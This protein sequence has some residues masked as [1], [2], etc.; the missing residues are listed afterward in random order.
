MLRHSVIRVLFAISSLSL[1][2]TPALAA[3]ENIS[4]KW[5]PLV[6]LPF[7]PSSGAT[8]PNG[9]VLLWSADG[10]FSF[11]TG[12]QV[13]TTLFDPATNASTPRRFQGGHNM[14]CTGTTNLADGRIL[15]N[16]GSQD[17]A[18]TIY[19]P[20]SNLLTRVQN[21]NQPRG[22]NSNT[23]LP[24]GS[25]LTLGGSWSGG[26]AD[27][28]GEVWTQA[29]GWRALSGVTTAPMT[30]SYVPGFPRD[31]HM[32]IAPAGNGRVFYAGPAPEM[33]WIDTEG[34]G[35]VQPAGVRGDD[36]F[37]SQGT[38]VMYDRG[39]I[40]KLGGT[41][42]GS[43]AASSSV[44]RID[45]NAG[46]AV[47]KLIP[48]SY[49]RVFHNSVVL[50]DGGVFV[51][52]GQTIGAAF[53]DA[54]A[55]LAT[56]LWNPATGAFTVTA[57]IAAPRTYH[58]IALLLPDGR[59]LS[60]GG[61]LCGPCTT[62][63]PDLQIYSPGYLFDSA[64]N[65]KPRPVI[66]NAP[67]ELA[68]GRTITVTTNRDVTAFSLVRMGSTTHTINNDQRRLPLTFVRTGVNTYQI[69]MPGNPGWMTPGFWM[70]FAMDASGTPSV[71]RI[72][73]AN[74]NSV[75]KLSAEA[76]YRIGAGAS[77]TI[78]P[79]VARINPSATFSISGLPAGLSFNA[80]TGAITGAPSVAGS[81]PVTLS[82]TDGAQTVS[83][84]FVI[85]IDQPSGTGSGLLADYFPSTDLSGA[86]ATSRV[87]RPWFADNAVGAG[88]GVN[89]A[90]FSARWSGVIV[91]QR[92]GTT[93]I[94]TRSDDGVRVW[95]GG[96][97][98]I[99]NWTIHG[100]AF[101]QG[102]VDL[103]AGARY[104]IL[105]EYY[106]GGGSSALQ[107]SWRRPGEAAFSAIPASQLYPGLPLSNANLALGR[108][109]T[110]SSNWSA[111]TVA[112][113]AVDGN[114]NG[115]FA[116][117][118]VSHTNSE[119]GAWWQVDLGAR[120][121]VGRIRLWN[122]TDCCGERLQNFYVFI[123][124]Q[125]QTG[126]TL[127]QILADPT[128]TRR[129]VTASRI[130]SN[131]TIQGAAAGRF[132]RVQLAGTNPLQLAEVEVFGAPVNQ[133]PVIAET[134]PS[135]ALT[136]GTPVSLQLS[137]TDP[138]G[139]AVV[140]S[141]TGA[142]SGLALSPTGLI[143]G[144]PN[145][146]GAGVAIIQATDASGL[147][148]TANVAWTVIAGLPSVSSLAVLPATTGATVSYA[149]AILNGEGATYRW[150]F[151]DGTA[152]TGFSPVV[153]ASHA[154]ASAGVFRVTLTMRASDGR[155]TTYS[156]NQA[157]YAAVAAGPRAQTNSGSAYERRAS[158]APRLWVANPD[159]DSVGVI[160]LSTNALVA[161][162]AV[163][164]RPASVGVHPNGDVW[165]VNR[166]S[167][168]LSVVDPSTLAVKQTIAMPRASRPYG[169]VF[170]G[171]SAVV[172]L[173][174]AESVALVSE[175]G[176]LLG[177]A[178][179][180]SSP[181]HITATT[182]GDGVLIS[183]F[184]TPPLPGE[185][186]ANVQTTDQNGR[187]VG[188]EI[189]QLNQSGAIV[190]TFVLKHSEA[191]DTEI[192]AR[193]V[194][195][196]LGAAA[197]SPDGATAW[198]PSKQDNIKRGALR[199][200]RDL[201]FQ[202]TVRA[203]LSKIDLR[204]GEEDLSSRVDLDNS[205]VASAAIFHPT[206]AYL[207]VALQ[208]SR[209]VAV[210]DPVGARELFRF[211]VG[212]APSHLT[213]SP[214]GATLYVTNFMDRT[215]SR[216]SLAPMLGN[217][218]NEVRVLRTIRTIQ[219]EKLT[220]TVLRGK[221]IFYDAA[222]PRIARDAYLSCAACHDN[223]E[224]DG[225]VW[226]FTGFGEGLRNTISLEGRTGTVHGFLHWSGNFDET[227]D[228]EGQIRSFAQGTGLMSDAAFNA[229]T[230]SQPLGDRK[231]GQSADL[232][233]LAAFLRSLNAFPE[234]PWRNG[235]GTLTAAAQAGKTAFTTFGCAMC[236]GG[237]RMTISG[238]AT[239]LRDVGTI[240][241]S[242]GQRLG[243][244]L[245]G[246]DPPTLLG[247]FATAPY[248]HDGSAATLEDAIRAHRNVT[249]GATDIANIAAYLR[250][251]GGAP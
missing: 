210:V 242:S 147:S 235:D 37:A 45:I 16:G 160:D 212:R 245:P 49:A 141:A 127:T 52:G 79:G 215:V 204:T 243:A 226:D 171:R 55:V 246:L 93:R 17:R 33:Q 14:F 250:Q 68:Y 139:Q 124:D 138:E 200:G 101:D 56:E 220:S 191:L 140:F 143:S 237:T 66:V 69:S 162:I 182:T 195:N 113:R 184:V 186:T 145:S 144:A 6:R 175:S 179:I 192:S 76:V 211:S 104:P 48:M 80:Q 142:P 152:P 28:K 70:L 84:E 86:I 117:G 46:V 190:R 51:V 112:A 97:L 244:P 85:A 53:S 150:E 169:L 50:P 88:A 222:D 188:G 123:S 105:I 36:T 38:A 119:T 136:F 29:G 173:E 218:L 129:S 165:V 110:Q 156:F 238:D 118:S 163:G 231:T 109:A 216:V 205:G 12:G 92:G 42:T 149:P 170:A 95:I 8:L 20:A 64:G 155:Q 54:N 91:A 62:N 223:A 158:G 82:A 199:D 58:S 1:V 164:R 78:Q 159:N 209:E 225:R 63:H 193:G 151:G 128:V 22:Y 72:M 174:A 203:I 67:S 23:I 196:Y 233:A 168:T 26:I 81:F 43:G 239:K 96:K 83:A 230:R 153:A 5:S 194:P 106:N 116:S 206:G 249:L 40:L 32:W 122:R 236:H 202:T 137:A 115:A 57:P 241:P 11:G 10:E 15:M 39:R 41:V 251:I 59:V 181:R 213:L 185:G 34:N 161:E 126:R 103:V 25:T 24:D 44:Y 224:H 87:E 2:V 146:L 131:I 201:D 13:Y 30:P 180:G 60:G 98:V 154:F 125:D 134:P 187:P 107:L 232:D 90:S 197:V 177:S 9:R 228:F 65:D 89:M 108:P 214:D 208:T 247:V 130:P 77:A 111:Q 71:S 157:V 219:T 7:V 114:A 100:A 61:G 19:D 234:S 31:S 183:R 35:S 132:V 229:G 176:V 94:Q 167:A 99:D 248:L 178:R 198:V 133:P 47:N 189:V 3:G 121:N 135:V 217:G 120:T 227:Q 148:S 18:T 207:F 4:G 240:K 27:K 102:E 75:A 74:V 221:R 73:R 172:T 21:M 166:D